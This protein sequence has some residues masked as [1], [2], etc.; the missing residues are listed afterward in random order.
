M[1]SD[2][3]L[4]W[5]YL[6]SFQLTLLTQKVET[7]GN[8]LE[9]KFLKHVV[10]E[11]RSE[12]H[13]SWD[14]TFF[15]RLSTLRKWTNDDRHRLRLSTPDHGRPQG[16]QNGHLPS[17][18]IG[19]KNRNFLENMKSAAQFRLID[20][21]VAMTVYFPVRHTA[22]ESGS[23][24]VLVSCSSGWACSSLVCSIAWPNLR[25]DTS[26]VG[27][28]CV[29]IT[30]SYHSRHFAACC[31]LLLNA[32]ILADNAARQWLLIAVSHVVLYCVERS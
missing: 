3:R 20:V 31:C 26:A 16:R 23:C 13:L 30:P 24:T 32:D 2:S 28:Y 11:S 18:E 15:V 1:K 7:F 22:Q 4:R 6:F 12:F 8:W 21:I 29:T 17:L 5:T 9:E 27:L 19:S 25:A 10:M 14:Y